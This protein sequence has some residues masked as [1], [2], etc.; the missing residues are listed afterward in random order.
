MLQDSVCKLQGGTA[1]S[2]AMTGRM[3]LDKADQATP[4]SAF[5]VVAVVA[6]VC[7]LPFIMAVIFACCCTCC[8][9]NRCATP[10]V[11]L[12]LNPRVPAATTVI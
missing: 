12:Q 1:S 11:S 3:L 6:G 2:A 7:L 4:A 5:I 10:C 9:F 8:R